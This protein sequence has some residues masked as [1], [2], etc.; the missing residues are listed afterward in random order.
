MKNSMF[1]PFSIFGIKRGLALVYEVICFSH[2]KYVDHSAAF[3]QAV[4]V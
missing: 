4:T 1:F 3:S 2:V